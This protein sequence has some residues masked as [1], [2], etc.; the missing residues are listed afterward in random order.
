MAKFAEIKE[1]QDPFDSTKTIWRVQR[2]VTVCN[3][4]VPSNGHV[5]GEN[6]CKKFFKGGTW[7]QTSYNTIKGVYYTPNDNGIRVKD[8]D[9]SKAFRHTYAG[10]EY[11]YDFTNDIFYLRQP[12]ASWI[13]NTTTYI[14]EAP[15]TYPSIRDDEADPSLWFY[16]IS[17]NETK[18]QADN[19]TGWEATKINDTADPKTVYNWNGT[20]W[21]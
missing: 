16:V 5:D 17:W 12:Y 7:K 8:P 19:N 14:W 4:V 2:V 10:V 11:V 3:S 6:W 13:L 1:V 9:Q 21:V 20:A 15:I 18:Y